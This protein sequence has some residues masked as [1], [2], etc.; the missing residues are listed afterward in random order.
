MTVCFYGS[1]SP[2]IPERYI[3]ATEALGEKL[4]RAGYDLVYGAGGEGLMG[5]V[6]RGFRRGGGH[7]VGVVPHFLDLGHNLFS[8]CDEMV[9][10]E[11]MSERKQKMEELADGFVIAPGGPGTFD[12]FFE[13]L[14]LKQL[15]RHGEPIVLWNDNG[16]YDDILSMMRHCVE[17][18]F[19]KERSLALFG[20]A[21]DAD[22]VISLLSRGSEAPVDILSMKFVK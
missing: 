14:A 20:I 9:Y 12:E 8:E 2:R 15:G 3:L 6:A 19:M 5:A 18:S 7:I 11:T 21:A 4:A 10:T 1:S 22:E 13:T 16:Y 17:E